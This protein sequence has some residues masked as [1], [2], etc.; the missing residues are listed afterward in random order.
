VLCRIALAGAEFVIV[1][2]GGDVVI[3]G[4]FFIGP[5]S[6]FGETGDL[7]ALLGSSPGMPG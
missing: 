7:F 5:V 3:R 2:V 4:E 6:G 1:V